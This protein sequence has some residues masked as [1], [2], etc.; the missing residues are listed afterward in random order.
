MDVVDDLVGTFTK[1]FNKL[2]LF[3]LL[4]KHRVPCAPVRTLMEVVN[5]PHLH[6]RGMLQ[7][8]DHPEHRPHRRAVEP[9]ALRRRAATRRT[10]RAALSVPSNE[11]VLSGWL[12]LSPD[13]VKRLA[14]EGVI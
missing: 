3:A 4:M 13:D 5:D 11:N 2:D 12:G 8:I 1:Q 7:W 14:S 6:E 9:D 10:S